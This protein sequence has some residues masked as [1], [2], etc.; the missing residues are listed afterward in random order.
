MACNLQDT[1]ILAGFGQ[2]GNVV[3]R[4]RS[5]RYSFSTRKNTTANTKGNAM[6]T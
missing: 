5:R 4:E 3:V 6:P 1:H 2:R